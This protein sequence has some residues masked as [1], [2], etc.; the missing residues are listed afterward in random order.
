MA[1]VCLCLVEVG[2]Y[3]FTSFVEEAEGVY[4]CPI[5]GL[6][7]SFT[8]IRLSRIPVALNLSPPEVP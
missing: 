1:R 4:T 7:E 5:Q 2:I 3:H 8:S 6:L